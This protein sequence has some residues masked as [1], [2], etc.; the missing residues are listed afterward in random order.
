MIANR[1][2]RL[3]AQIMRNKTIEPGSDLIGGLSRKG[4]IRWHPSPPLAGVPWGRVA[5]PVPAEYQLYL[6][7]SV[8]PAGVE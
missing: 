7:A 5:R 2:R 8:A 3:S 6:P 1:G 4:A